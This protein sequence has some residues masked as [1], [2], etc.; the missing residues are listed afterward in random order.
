MDGKPNDSF[1]LKQGEQ[2]AAQM[3]QIQQIMQQRGMAAYGSW[4]DGL[5]TLVA[6]ARTGNRGAR[7]ALRQA[8]EALREM[9]QL[10]AIELPG[11]N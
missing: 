2:A 3:A 10:L 11:E 7:S 1:L 6:Q 8:R 5:T 4:L 9:E